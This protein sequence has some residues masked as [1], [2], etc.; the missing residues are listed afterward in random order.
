[1]LVWFVANQQMLNRN[2]VNVL[3]DDVRHACRFKN[4]HALIYLHQ[5]CMKVAMKLDRITIAEHVLAG[6]TVL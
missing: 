5:N 4:C 6:D 3:H 2:T 1:M